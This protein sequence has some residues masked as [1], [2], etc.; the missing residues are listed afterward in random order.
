MDVRLVIYGIWGVGT[1]LVYGDVLRRRWRADRLHHDARSRRDLRSG[2]ALFLTAFA[3]FLAITFV[4]FGEAGTG[5]RGLF[6]S[7]ALGAF[8][9][10][11][12]V[13]RADEPDEHE[14]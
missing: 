14:P 11:G 5:I 10:A 8:L 12:W 7:I 9:G 4:L 6:V 3:S 2:I 1:V 13:M